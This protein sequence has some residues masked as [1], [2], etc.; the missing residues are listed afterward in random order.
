MC[1][2]IA[3][4]DNLNIENQIQTYRVTNSHAID[5]LNSFIELNPNCRLFSCSYI[6][7]HLFYF[8]EQIAT[9]GRS[10]DDEAGLIYWA[11]L[12]WVWRVMHLNEQSISQTQAIIEHEIARI[13][14][15]AILTELRNVYRIQLTFHGDE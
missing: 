1:V 4:I 3:P 15:D 14:S 9:S 2:G 10:D 13:M 12:L 11:S 8:A 7:S 6:T 5:C